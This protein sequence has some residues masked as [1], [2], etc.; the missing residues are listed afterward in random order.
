MM[1]NPQEPADGG[2]PHVPSPDEVPS[3]YRTTPVN[4]LLNIFPILISLVPMTIGWH[5]YRFPATA[6]V[7]TWEWWFMLGGLFLYMLT[8]NGWDRYCRDSGS[9]PSLAPYS[10]RVW[11]FGL[12]LRFPVACGLL[13]PLTRLI[14]MVV[15]VGGFASLIHHLRH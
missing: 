3:N 5:D 13:V 6:F 15:V 11:W 1:H 12:G 7:A 10:I 4:T 14:M 2:G 8:W 9:H